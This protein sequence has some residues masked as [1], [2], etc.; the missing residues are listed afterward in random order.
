MSLSLLRRRRR[1]A[2]PAGMFG[3]DAV[4]VRADGLSLGASLA[5]SFA[6]VGYP[7]EVGLGW[8]EPLL[9]HPDRLDVALHVEPTPRAV[10]ADRLRRQLARLESGRRLDQSRGRIGDPEVETAAADAADL[11]AR[12][13][14]G[15]EK[16]FRVGLYLTVYADDRDS[17]EAAS[18]RVRGLCQSLLLDAQPLTFRALQGW[19]TTLPLGVDLIRLRRS[20]D[21]SAL[22]ASFPF[23][24]GELGRDSGVLYGVA[25][26]GS[27]LVLWDRF[28][29]DNHNA[30]IL[31]RSGAG[32]SY[33]AKLELLRSLYTGVEVSVIDPEDKYAR[34]AGGVGGTYVH[35]GA[36]GVRLN[37]L[38]LGPGPD[39]LIRQALFIHT[40]VAVLL[41]GSPDPAARAALDRTIVAAYR[42]VGIT[43]DPRTH[44]RPAPVLAD[45]ARVLGEDN[46]PAARTLAARLAPFVTGTHRALFDGPTTT[47]P[48]GHLVVFSLRDLP[49]EIKAVGTLLTLDAVWRRVSNP[50][51]RRRRLVVVDEAWLL[52]REPEGARFLFRMAKSARKHWCGLT[53]VTQDSGDLLGSDLG[54]AVVANATT[55]ILLRQAPQTVDALTEAFHL[56]DG[57]RA[58]LL[59]ARQ[60]EGLLAAGSDRV[61]FQ[62]VASPTEHRLVTS[63][64]A[65]LA[66]EEPDL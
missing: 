27:G 1:T 42:A 25:S 19:I 33:L 18:S 41:G 60:G 5:R 17:L 59:S 21:T 31:A 2:H 22:A 15:E 6:V 65:E 29:L 51:D 34:L 57:E 48:E 24:S 46:D 53:V 10:A 9:T 63:D 38:D 61:A 8:L 26:K 49:D 16:L 39:A 13:A 54:Q 32:K 11:A 36:P 35:L 45:L 52:M 62:T 58:F 12:L 43:A 56:S 47:R 55:Q 4:E 28:G 64:P 20:F 23:A 30:V 7:R 44:A 50:A 66:A 3:P 14:R 40:L 37:P